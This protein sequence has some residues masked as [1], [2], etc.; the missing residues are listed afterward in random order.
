MFLT[1]GGMAKSTSMAH[2]WLAS[3][4]A[5]KRDQPYSLT[6]AWLCCHQSFSLLRSAI[7]CLQGAHSSSRH[8]THNGPVDLIVSKGQVPLEKL[9]IKSFCTQLFSYFSFV[10]C[11]MN[12]YIYIYIYLALKKKTKIV[13]TFTTHLQ[14][15]R[16]SKRTSTNIN[17]PPTRIAEAKTDYP[18]FY[19]PHTSST[20]VKTDSP[21]F[22]K[23]NTRSAVVKM[24]CLNFYKPLQ[25]ATSLPGTLWWSKRTLRTSTRLIHALWW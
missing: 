16:W 17:N 3:M 23:V 4:L 21:N 8:A 5:R 15:S 24:D 7:T 1:S 12:I 20:E 19:K 18:N 14:A 25:S 11:S 2:K 10:I 22:Y 9:R 6:I 13:R